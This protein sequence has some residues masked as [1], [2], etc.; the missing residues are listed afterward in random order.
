[1]E[2]VVMFDHDD[3][4]IFS[5]AQNL[6]AYIEFQ[7]FS[8]NEEA[9]LENGSILKLFIDKGGYVK[10]LIGR[11]KWVDDFLYV[12]F[13]ITDDFSFMEEIRNRLQ[14]FLINSEIANGKDATLSELFDLTQNVVGVCF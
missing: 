12:N 11:K 10:P 9:Y 1:M 7:S 4:Y 13:E 14:K 6:C 5:S 2:R 3:I 8:G